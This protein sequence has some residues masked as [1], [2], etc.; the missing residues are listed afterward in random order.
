MTEQTTATVQI[1]DINDIADRY[2]AV[3]SEPDTE[4]RRETIAHLWSDNAVELIE[5]AE[6]HGL[7]ELEPRITEAYQA[8]VESGTFT[9]SSANDVIGHHDLISFTIQLT[10]PGGE[11]AWAARVVLLLDGDGRIERDYHL[12]VQELAAQ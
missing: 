5:E 9:V 10:P 2:I 12:T 6:F 7:A 3:W 1:N 11:V 8:F 4:A